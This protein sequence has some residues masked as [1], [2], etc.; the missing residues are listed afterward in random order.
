M[1]LFDNIGKKLGVGG[2]LGSALDSTGSLFKGN[3]V[4]AAP[5][6]VASWAQNAWNRNT[7]GGS[8]GSNS[9]SSSGTEPQLGGLYNPL[10]ASGNLQ[11]QYQL[12]SGYAANQDALNALKERA[13][14][15]GDSPW[16][17]MSLEK[18]GLDEQKALD[19]ANAQSTGSTAAARSNLGM[20]GGLSAGAAERLGAQ[21]AENALN[22]GQ[23]I[24]SQGATDRLG[25]QIA[26]DQTK[27]S[28]LSQIPQMD[29]NYANQA[30]DIQKYNINNALTAGQNQN[31]SL[32]DR[33]KIAMQ[34]YGANQ[35]ANAIANSE[36]AG[37]FGGKGF[38]G[39][40][41]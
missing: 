28:L 26:D 5:G 9:T 34:G 29:L 35:T 6:A 15:T 32:L 31:Q 3:M 21:G 22:A 25:L 24:R 12:S 27:T 30:A 13:M 16:L 37:L 1:A 17:S 4:T 11:S 14:G 38:L 40:G 8:S 10:D 23:N 19:A 41:I 2:T 36:P 20:R 7:G 39:L 33:Y 18:Q